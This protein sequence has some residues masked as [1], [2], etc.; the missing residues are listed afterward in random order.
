MT[1][2]QLEP[3]KSTKPSKSA[4]AILTSE[5]SQNRSK[6]Y[7]T[8]YEKGGRF[9]VKDNYK[10]APWFR[11]LKIGMNFLWGGPDCVLTGRPKRGSILITAS[12]NVHFLVNFFQKI[13]KNISSWNF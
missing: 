7:N 8:C 4:V 1:F 5:A 3:S 2:G 6:L 13:I 9:V 11:K 10:N 12:T